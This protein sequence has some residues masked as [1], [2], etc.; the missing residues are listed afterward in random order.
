MGF[1]YILNPLACSTLLSVFI[2]ST[3]MIVALI[4]IPRPLSNDLWMILCQKV[5]AQ[6][7]K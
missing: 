4:D 3:C 5:D 7:V 2:Q 6:H 1:H